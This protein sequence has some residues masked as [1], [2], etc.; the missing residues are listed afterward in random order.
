[1]Q[2]GHWP[3][4]LP[5]LQVHPWLATGPDILLTQFQVHHQLATRLGLFFVSMYIIK[6]HDLFFNSC[7]FILFMNI[8]RKSWKINKSVNIILIHQY[9]LNWWKL[10]PGLVG[11]TNRSRT[12]KPWAIAHQNGHL[13][14]KGCV[15]GHAYEMCTRSHGTKKSFR[16]PKTM[17]NSTSKR[18]FNMERM[19]FW[20]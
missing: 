10:L 2:L 7:T 8:F 17:G 12:P 3:F 18:S 13:I 14:P 1:M 6:I 19:I 5:Q 16:N 11:F 15:I 9:V 4:Y 20:S